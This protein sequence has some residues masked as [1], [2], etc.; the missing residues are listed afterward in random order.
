MKAIEAEVMA[1]KPVTPALE[2]AINS[3]IPSFTPKLKIL[4]NSVFFA[5]NP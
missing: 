5:N 4:N 3:T 2:K 1:V